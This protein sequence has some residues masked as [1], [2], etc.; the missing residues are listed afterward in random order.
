MPASGDAPGS[1]GVE[2]NRRWRREVS[3]TVR[4]IIP[5][6]LC[7]VFSPSFV[8]AQTQT[9]GE[10]QGFVTT[11]TG[12]VRLPGAEVTVKDDSDRQVAQ[13]ACG[14]DGRFRVPDLPPGRYHVSASLAEFE[15]AQA[16]AVV[17]AGK[18]TDLSIDLPIGKVKD[19]VDV[20]ATS[21][22]VSTGGPISTTDLIG[23][24]GIA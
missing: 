7:C 22:P 16:D 2:C 17:T 4:A 20:V 9:S 11:Q 13:V 3:M 8:S 23:R 18:T 10:I 12:T 15:T 1:I 6:L 14:E 24:K 5:Y 21:S 19:S